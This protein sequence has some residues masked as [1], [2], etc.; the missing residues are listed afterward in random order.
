MTC[1]HLW[2]DNKLYNC[3]TT[4]SQKDYDDTSETFEALKRIA[5]LCN[6]A[7]FAPEVISSTQTVVVV[8]VVNV[9]IVVVI[10]LNVVVVVV[11]N[12]VVIV[13]VVIVVVL[14]YGETS[15]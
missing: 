2:Y 14:G 11:V 6:R 12:V 1:S 9:V 4:T 13:V 15:F 10:V 7:N 3:P 8:N 5:I